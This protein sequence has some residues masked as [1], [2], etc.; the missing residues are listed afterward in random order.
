M[1]GKIQFKK[2]LEHNCVY[3]MF[4]LMSMN[5]EAFNFSFAWLLFWFWI[6]THND[7]DISHTDNKEGFCYCW[8]WGQWQLHYVTDIISIKY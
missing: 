4:R 6:H 7:Q 8:S 5:H 3:E 1:Y 2:I